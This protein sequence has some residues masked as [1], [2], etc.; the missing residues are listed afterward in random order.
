MMKHS[1]IPRQLKSQVSSARLLKS[2]TLSA[3][4]LWFLWTFT[5]SNSLHAVL[6][7]PSASQRKPCYPFFEEDG[8]PLWFTFLHPA[9]NS[10]VSSGVC[11][12]ESLT[13]TLLLV[14]LLPLPRQNPPQSAVLLRASYRARSR[15]RGAS[16]SLS[17]FPTGCVL[18]NPLWWLCFWYCICVLPWP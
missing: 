12:G 3:F 14:F 11:V 10:G 8:P 5:L 6:V 17:V 7:G 9:F 4:C 1:P 16:C 2:G 13:H 18:R 15:P